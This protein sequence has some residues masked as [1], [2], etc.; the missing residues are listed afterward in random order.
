MVYV[1]LNGSVFSEYPPPVG[2]NTYL[3]SSRGIK[4]LF[5]TNKNENGFQKIKAILLAISLC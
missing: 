5:K 3:F 2:I 4:A 1:A